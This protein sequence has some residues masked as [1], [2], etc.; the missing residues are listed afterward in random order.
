MKVDVN[1]ATL[2]SIHNPD[3]RS[4]AGQY[5][6]IYQDF[7]DQVRQTGLEVDSGDDDSQ[8]E[9]RL[10]ALQK[11]GA[12]SRNDSKSIYARRISSACQACKTGVESDTFFISLKCHRDCFYCFNPNQEDYQ[13]YREHTRDTVAELQALRTSGARVRHLA[14]TGGEPLLQKE[15][16]LRFFQAARQGFPGVYT[17]LYTCGDHIDRP[18]LQ[19]LKD[20]A[21]NEI[22]FSIRMQDLARG[23]RHTFEQIALAREYIPHV[24]VEMPVLP[25]TFEEMKSVLIELDRLEIF[26]INLLEF[27]FPY[28]NADVFR[29]RGYKIKARPYRVL[30]NYLY[31][32]GLPVAGSQAVC[33]DLLE[34]AL[35]AGLNLGV[36]YCS[37][38]NKHTGQIYQQNSVLPLPKTMFFSQTD[39]FLKS[40][41]V[42]GAD[43]A[44]VR[45]VFQKIG[46]TNYTINAEHN[47]LEFHVSQ[48]S[49]LKKLDIEIGLSFNVCET[50]NGERY[51]RELKVDCTTPQTFKLSADI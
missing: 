32:G 20:S 23:Q 13:Y 7:M 36:H 2:A 9:A 6:R 24:M 11:Q 16:A 17:R 49:A 30:Y 33:L 1:A 14:L 15:E 5:L 47:Y 3:L 37:L 48:I 19:A 40:A 51:M 21:M 45:Q 8:F 10:A 29:E 18:T 25:G 26:G 34:F 50:R 46:Y 43:I 4:Y 42:F 27:C 38:E 12:Q 31:G 39:Y 28:N 41:K 22:R 44:P 35:D